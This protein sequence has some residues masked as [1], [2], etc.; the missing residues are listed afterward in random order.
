MDTLEPPERKVVYLAEKLRERQRHTCSPEPTVVADI[1]IALLSTGRIRFDEHNVTQ[2][3]AAN[4]AVACH[5]TLGEML[6]M[7]LQCA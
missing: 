7:L 3:N 2:R 4:F 5:K 1:S 6:K